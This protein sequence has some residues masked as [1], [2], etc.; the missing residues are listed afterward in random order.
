MQR[1]ISVI[2]EVRLKDE[3]KPM[4]YSY[5]EGGTHGKKNI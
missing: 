5:I 3:D 2:I 1:V 4:E